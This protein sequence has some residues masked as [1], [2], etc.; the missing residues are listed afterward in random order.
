MNDTAD[1]RYAGWVWI[2]KAKDEV[3]LTPIYNQS[4][5]K[6][7]KKRWVVI[8]LTDLLYFHS[9]SL[10]E[11]KSIPLTTLTP[12]IGFDANDHPSTVYLIDSVGRWIEVVLETEDS[13]QTAQFCS[14]LGQACTYNRLNIIRNAIS[15]DRESIL[16]ETLTHCRDIKEMLENEKF[17]DQGS[18]FHFMS[19][20]GSVSCIETVFK[21]MGIEALH[22]WNSIGNPP[23]HVAVLAN[24]LNYIKQLLLFLTQ[25]GESAKDVVNIPDRTY[26]RPLHI[27]FDE[28]IVAILLQ[29]GADIEVQDERGIVP[30]MSACRRGDFLAAI[31]LMDAGARVNRASWSGGQTP[32]MLACQPKNDE[33]LRELMDRG[34]DIE[35]CDNQR[36]TALHYACMT[37]FTYGCVS[38]LNGGVDADIQDVYGATALCYAA[39]VTKQPTISKE[40]VALLLARGSYPKIR[41]AFGRQAIHYAAAAGN[42]AA[43]TVLLSSG[44]DV[45]AVDHKG[46]TA[47]EVAER[48]LEILNSDPLED[49]SP[50]DES[51]ADHTDDS[52]NLGDFSREYTS[53]TAQLEA[54][55]IHISK[56]SDKNKWRVL[57]S[58]CLQTLR[59]SGA[60]QRVIKSV[61]V[62]QNC[63]D[64]TFSYS[65]S[66]GTYSVATATP[67]AL[68]SRIITF[69]YFTT[70]QANNLLATYRLYMEPTTLLLL[71]RLRFYMLHSMHEEVVSI[72]NSWVYSLGIFLMDPKQIYL[73]LRLMEAEYME[74]LNADSDNVG[75]SNTDLIP[76]VQPK[77]LSF[78]IS[79][80]AAAGNNIEAEKNRGLEGPLTFVKGVDSYIRLECSGNVMFRS[81]VLGR[82]VADNIDTILDRFISSLSAVCGLEMFHDRIVALC[83]RR[84]IQLC[85]V[86][87]F[88]EYNNE[89]NWRIRLSDN[90]LSGDPILGPLPSENEMIFSPAVPQEAFSV[91]SIELVCKPGHRMMRRKAFMELHVHFQDMASTSPI[92]SVQHL[93]ETCK[94]TFCEVFAGALYTF[95]HGNSNYKISGNDSRKSQSLSQIKELHKE[96]SVNDSEVGSIDIDDGTRGSIH[97]LSS[98]RKHHESLPSIFHTMKSVEKQASVEGVIDFPTSPKRQNSSLALSETSERSSSQSTVTVNR[99]SSTVDPDQNTDVD[100]N[101]ASLRGCLQLLTIWCVDFY[102]DDFERDSSLKAAMG[103]FLEEV[104]LKS[105]DLVE[106]EFDPNSFAPFLKFEDSQFNTS[107]PDMVVEDSDEFRA[108]PRA[109]LRKQSVLVVARDR[110]AQRKNSVMSKRVS[111]KSTA[112]PRKR[113]TVL[114]TS[115]SF[116]FGESEQPEIVDVRERRSSVAVHI[117]NGSVAI[118]FNILDLEPVEVAEQVTLL[119]HNLFC[120]V[121]R[122][123]LIDSK[124]ETYAN[125]KELQAFQIHWMDW[126][127]SQVVGSPD[128]GEASKKIAF[129]LEMSTWM[130][131]IR[132]YNGMFQVLTVL[133][134]TSVYRLRKAWDQLKSSAT[135]RHSELKALFSSK[136]GFIAFR[137]FLKR[138]TIQPPCLPYMGLY[139]KD[140]IYIQQLPNFVSKG[141]V[142]VTKMSSLASKLVELHSYQGTPYH[143]TSNSYVIDVLKSPARYRTEDEQYAAS[144]TLEPVA[145]KLK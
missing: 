10:T 92:S 94:N 85:D 19:H 115:M 74:K 69:P 27:T 54:Q 133:E 73:Q 123:E 6:K 38:L 24:K 64:I 117:G 71:I 95:A 52:N 39:A 88:R 110:C 21:Y 77:H 127:I 93:L 143:F 65:K 59:S 9:S 138:T 76:P 56:L 84:Y 86:V 26:Q 51:H 2:Q 120:R 34:A 121:K 47:Y 112:P 17:S 106:N 103:K 100:C 135:T 12:L 58:D 55:G 40:I 18:A 32:L 11:K 116:G 131:R 124:Q 113:G 4:N 141:I 45:N 130:E 98:A 87:V 22:K 128:T 28:E 118:E 89:S 66:L 7:R 35:A 125:L 111:T 82:V 15:C 33:L 108:P 102:E 119:E 99:A 57:Y 62:E 42:A 105:G 96:L 50:S 83:G 60:V 126:M 75:M 144:V 53:F 8:T 91:S 23:L 68:V 101:V 5:F 29:H 44:A 36:R 43:L 114:F 142:N 129:L 16:I 107:L 145:Q 49:A 41:D 104:M 140:I 122:T 139:L 72:V 70:H 14:L 134:S 3:E 1:N 20:C 30:L 81:V 63:R 80:I 48:N 61:P 97:S 132:N 13:S 37:G 46:H 137:Q 136:S 109:A 25:Q 67:W 90:G 31:E 79:S 78:R